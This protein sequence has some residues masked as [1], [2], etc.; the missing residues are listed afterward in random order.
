MMAA[1][2]VE[3]IAGVVCVESPNSLESIVAAAKH[4]YPADV[5][6]PRM[7]KHFDVEELTRSLGNV[8]TIRPRDASG[9]IIR[10]DPNDTAVKWIH[11]QLDLTSPAV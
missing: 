9:A 4:P 10:D 5:F 3:Q 8:L 7:L 11:R 6:L 2:A 1:A